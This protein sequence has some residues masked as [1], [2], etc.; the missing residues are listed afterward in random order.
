MVC[1]ELIMLIEMGIT[2]V[3]YEEVTEVSH[4][5]ADHINN[6]KE[7]QPERLNPETCDN[8]KVEG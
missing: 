5:I 3:T 8:K 1:K 2:V 4:K 7:C 6:C